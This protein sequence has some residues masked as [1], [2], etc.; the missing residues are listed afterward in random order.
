MVKKCPGR[1]DTNPG[2][3]ILH[4][5]LEARNLAVTLESD[6]PFSLPTYNPMPSSTESSLKYLSYATPPLHWQSLPMVQPL[7]I[8]CLD[9][10]QSFLTA[11]PAAVYDIDA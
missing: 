5:P 10:H 1:K 7:S 9:L 2:N 3:L 4:L 11:L 6:L 8:S